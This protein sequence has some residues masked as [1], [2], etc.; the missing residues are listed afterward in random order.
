MLLIYACNLLMCGTENSA[1]CLR[2]F[3]RVSAQAAPIFFQRGIA[4]PQ[5]KVIFY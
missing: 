5:T 4:N 2:D 3:R 1:R